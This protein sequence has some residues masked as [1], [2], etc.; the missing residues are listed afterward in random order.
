MEEYRVRDKSDKSVSDCANTRGNEHSPIHLRNSLSCALR[1]TEEITGLKK[2]KK[3][4]SFCSR[5]WQNVI[6]MKLGR[7][8]Q[9][10][11]AFTESS[12]WSTSFCQTVSGFS[13]VFQ[14]VNLSSFSSLSRVFFSLSLSLLNS[15]E[16][17]RNGA[18][19]AVT[20]RLCITH[21]PVMWHR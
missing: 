14:L 19:A 12:S 9:L 18:A 20:A 6:K 16:L 21:Q 1:V 3:S 17:I 8:W 10:I 4:L 15:L 11:N 7:F 2:R 5:G 13:F